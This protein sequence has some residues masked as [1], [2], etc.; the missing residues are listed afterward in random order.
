M[1]WIIDHYKLTYN[2]IYVGTYYV[3][4]DNTYNYSVNSWDNEIESIKDLLEKKRLVERQRI[5]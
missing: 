5:E 2:D 3:Y 4:Y 1:G